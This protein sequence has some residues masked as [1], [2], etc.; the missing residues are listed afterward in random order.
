MSTFLKRLLGDFHV[1]RHQNSL[2]LTLLGKEDAQ[3]AE[4]ECVLKT[5]YSLLKL[6]LWTHW[7]YKITN[8][9][10]KS[11][12]LRRRDVKRAVYKKGITTSTLGSFTFVYYECMEIMFFFSWSLEV[13]YEEVRWE[14]YRKTSNIKTNL[15]FGAPPIVSFG[16]WYLLS[17]RNIS[18]QENELLCMLVRF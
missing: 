17:S 11:K 4:M 6:F 5:N 16:E 3:K 14:A 18:S 12:N 8:L 13:H 7:E 1:L 9:N 10:S 15:R 2:S